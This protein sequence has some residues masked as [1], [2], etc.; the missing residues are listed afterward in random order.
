[1]AMSLSLSQVA[2][3]PLDAEGALRYYIGPMK[4]TVRTPSHQSIFESRSER[5]AGNHGRTGQPEPWRRDGTLLEKSS[6]MET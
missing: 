6:L 1:M 3:D 2:I 4:G 5:P